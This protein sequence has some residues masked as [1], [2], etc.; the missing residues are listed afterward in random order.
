MSVIPGGVN[1]RRNR[2]RWSKIERECKQSLETAAGANAPEIKQQVLEYFRE[3]VREVNTLK[4]LRA[5]LEADLA[6]GNTRSN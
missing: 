5:R 3:R 2:K 1:H 4:R 6:T